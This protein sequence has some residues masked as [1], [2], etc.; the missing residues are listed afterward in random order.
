M[1]LA[2]CIFI[3]YQ[4]RTINKTLQTN[5]IYHGMYLIREKREQYAQQRKPTNNNIDSLTPKPSYSETHE[6]DLVTHDS[7]SYKAENKS[8]LYISRA[9]FSFEEIDP[10][11]FS[12]KNQRHTNRTQCAEKTIKRLHN[13]NNRCRSSTMK[14]IQFIV[15]SNQRVRKEAQTEARKHRVVQQMDAQKLQTLLHRNGLVKAHSNAP[16]ELK[17]NILKSVF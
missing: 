16:E 1:L 14:R 11:S 2:S 17:R 4:L 12:T 10:D 8:A 3:I 15:P 6:D 5:Q 9:R 13:R 7:D